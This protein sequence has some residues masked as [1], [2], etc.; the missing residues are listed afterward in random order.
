M[1]LKYRIEQDTDADS[2]S[3]WGDNGDCFIVAKHNLFYIP[4]SGQKTIPYSANELVNKYKATHWIFPLEAYIHSGVILALSGEG[5]FPDRQ[6]DVSQL[7]FV[8]VSKKN[9]RLNK[10]AR[11]AALGLIASWNQYLSG[12][13][14]GYII[15]D[16][17]GNEIDSLW[18]MYGR[19]WCETEAKHAIELTPS[20]NVGELS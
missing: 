5:N 7:G 11:K 8:F 9:W 16:E 1:K 12:D 20:A 3:S 13:V 4:E 15:E 10:S 17:S 18:G 14:W 6:W 2:P 19:E